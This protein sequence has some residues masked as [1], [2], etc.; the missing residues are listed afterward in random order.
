MSPANDVG[1][2][3]ERPLRAAQVAFSPPLLLSTCRVPGSRVARF[4]GQMRKWKPREGVKWLPMPQSGR[5]LHGFSLCFLVG[6]RG[7]QSCS[8]ETRVL[9]ACVSGGQRAGGGGAEH[10]GL[11][12]CRP[13]SGS[14]DLE[15]MSVMVLRTQGPAALFDDHRLV[16]HTS[17]DDAKRARVF[18]AYGEFMHSTPGGA[19]VSPPG[20]GRQALLWLPG[21]QG[22]E[23]DQ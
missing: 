11:L 12:S 5:H 15:D 1:L 7:G 16:L 3:L 17:S 9:A 18:H 10:Q 13:L 20:A 8:S 19:S 4:S 21:V 23:E 2:R 22:S 6:S 14:T